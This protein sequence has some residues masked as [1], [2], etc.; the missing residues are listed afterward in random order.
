MLDDL[1]YRLEQYEARLR[2]TRR[3]LGQQKHRRATTPEETLAIAS[4]LSQ[5][6]SEADAVASDLNA[7]LKEE[8]AK[9]TEAIRQRQYKALMKKYVPPASRDKPDFGSEKLYG[10]DED[11][12]AG[13]APVPAFPKR[14][15][16]VLSGGA[17]RRFE[18]SDEPPRN[19]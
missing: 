12:S 10:S 19:P 11:G 17:A 18:E 8:S 2:E 9:R 16:P 3:L 15:V 5:A 6:L 7:R 1:E 14:P 13:N 4:K